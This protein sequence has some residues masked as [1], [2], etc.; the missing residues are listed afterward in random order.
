MQAAE[1]QSGGGSSA[2]AP[3]GEAAV[4]ACS[5]AL[6]RMLLAS[7]APRNL[8]GT[9]ESGATEPSA[10]GTGGSGAAASAERAAAGKPRVTQSV[11]S[12]RKQRELEKQAER[13]REAFGAAASLGLSSRRAH[14]HAAAH[15]SARR[16]SPSSPAFVPPAG[17]DQ[18]ALLPPPPP[19]LP[20]GAASA[21]RIPRE[22]L[23]VISEST[24]YMTQQEATR[25][26]EHV[27][28]NHTPAA[29]K[30]REQR[31]L[32]KQAAQAEKRARKASR[33][34]AAA[35]AANGQASSSP[36]P[37][38]PA[39]VPGESD[40]PAL[41]VPVTHRALSAL[42]GAGASGEPGRSRCH[43]DWDGASQAG[44]SE[45]SYFTERWLPSGML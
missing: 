20:P 32:E 2:V 11:G 28:A 44:C 23:D 5:E 4:E 17:E 8:S 36:D 30:T 39:L 7:N 27:L 43:G 3:M 33:R 22:A 15:A 18:H 10:S 19:P 31:A 34:L 21:R 40:F 16:E 45:A 13:R 35:A 37:A 29:Y 25:H 38:T 42:S 14:I 9:G 26:V 41:V 24:G 6:H 1:A 12:Q